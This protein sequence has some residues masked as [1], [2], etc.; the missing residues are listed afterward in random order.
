[1]DNNKAASFSLS[2]TDLARCSEEIAAAAEVC[3]S[4]DNERLTHT[5]VWLKNSLMLLI[6]ALDNETISTLPGDNRGRKCT[7]TYAFE[8]FERGGI[9]F[10]SWESASTVIK[11]VIKVVSGSDAENAGW[12]VMGLEA[13]DKV[14]NRLFAHTDAYERAE[15][16]YRVYL[17]EKTD[18]PPA[19]GGT[20]NGNGRSRNRESNDRQGR[21]TS[22]GFGANFGGGGGSSSGGSGGQQRITVPSRR[23]A[24]I[25]HFWCFSPGVTLR[26]I[27]N[28]GVGSMVLTSGTLAPLKSFATQLREPFP[29][30]LEGPHVIDNKRQL[31]VGVVTKGVLGRKLNS[32]YRYRSTSA[33]QTE[34]GSTVAN[35]ARIIPQGLLVFFPSYPVMTGCLN[36]WR[37][38]VALWQ[39]IEKYKTPYVEPRGSA[40]MV[41][42]VA[43]YE[44][45][46]NAGKG[47]IFFA[48]CR[49]KASEGIDFSD[50]RARGVIVTGLPFSPMVRTFVC[51]F[52][53]ACLLCCCVDVC[54]F[55]VVYVVHDSYRK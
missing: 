5:L 23:T 11:E 55:V 36:S 8:F 50:H 46:V 31:W 3:L 21:S 29:S 16:F 17:E 24:R 6:A 10:K 53:G 12:Q 30:I 27:R 19:S 49:G 48:V 51:A 13:F 25:L 33:Y 43:E 54:R 22:F 32:S 28:L 42:V 52:V 44:E 34:L 26:D 45:A 9:T 37:K 39:R 38:D 7:G 18:A 35:F 14:L 41:R 20:N 4:L 40:E 47:A 15:Q 2:T 1:L